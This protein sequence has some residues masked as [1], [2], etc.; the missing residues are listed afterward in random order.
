MGSVDNVALDTLMSITGAT[1]AVITR[2][3]QVPCSGIK[4]LIDL[5]SNRGCSAS[6]LRNFAQTLTPRYIGV[7][8]VEWRTCILQAAGNATGPIK[9]SAE[10]FVLLCVKASTWCTEIVSAD[11]QGRK[12]DRD[13]SVGYLSKIQTAVLKLVTGIFEGLVEKYSPLEPLLFEESLA[14]DVERLI[15]SSFAMVKIVY[16][17]SMKHPSLQSSDNEGM[18]KRCHEL[19]SLTFRLV[20][21]FRR[22]VGGSTSAT[23]GS[24]AFDNQEGC[25]SPERWQLQATSLRIVAS[26]IRSLSELGDLS[27]RGGAISLGLLNVSWKSVVALLQLEEGRDSVASAVDI[28]NIFSSLLHH[29]VQALKAA[30]KSW[31]VSSNSGE[32]DARRLCIPVKFFLQ[33]AEKISSFYPQKAVI[34]SAS[35]ISILSKVYASLLLRYKDVVIQK[36]AMQV[37]AE[38]VIP[39]AIDVLHNLLKAQSVDKELKVKLLHMTTSDTDDLESFHSIAELDGGQEENEV[40][41]ELFNGKT[42]GLGLLKTGRLAIFVSLLQLSSH[43]DIILLRELTLKLH[44]LLDAAPD[45]GVYVVLTQVRLLPIWTADDKITW[46]SQLIFTWLSHS[47]QCFAGVGARDDHVW[48]EFQHFLLENVLHPCAVCRELILDVWCFVIRHC[49]AI[50]AQRHIEVLLSLL[51]DLV[52][53]RVDRPMLRRLAR[54]LCALV[55]E[56]PEILAPRVDADI[57]RRDP[58]SSEITATLA[59]L[60]LEEGYSVTLLN[61]GSRK[62]SFNRLLSCCIAGGKGLVDSL[63][64][65]EINFSKFSAQKH[66]LT[67]LQLLLCESAF[68]GEEIEVQYLQ[69]IALIAQDLLSKTVQEAARLA[70]CR[71]A[72]IVSHALQL[73]PHVQH[74]LDPLYL[75]TL[76][77]KL[78]DCCVVPSRGT[79]SKELKQALPEFLANLSDIVMTEEEENPAMRALWGLFHLVL[80]ETHWALVHMGLA[81]FS[82]YAANTSCQELWRFVPHDAALARKARGDDVTGDVF[83]SA[84]KSFI[85]KE[86]AEN[87][88][89][90]SD[91]EVQLLRSEGALLHKFTDNGVSRRIENVDLD[92]MEIDSVIKDSA[93]VNLTL[94]MICRGTAVLKDILPSWLA[95]KGSGS[96]QWQSIRMRLADLKEDI[97]TLLQ[98]E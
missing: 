55:E 90:P 67:S 95:A 21:T 22:H 96:H 12:S 34:A 81:S 79:T 15:S 92:E 54:V 41:D 60:L 36:T 7:E 26:S 86:G 78:Y 4:L 69:E 2:L 88:L 52:A 1:E 11:L 76:L 56:I 43:Y 66:A 71:N 17:S 24:S 93:E 23:A 63:K 97:G 98:L 8:A 84:L 10:S 80:K 6:N 89:A 75:Q 25:Q 72:E 94:D 91:E 65:E 37:L 83:M 18:R 27:T 58:F 33:M 45:Q 64:Q 46:N 16:L 5:G 49:D 31:L 87:S 42:S 35:I 73:I 51:Q 70:I 9:E 68:R 38:L 62:A 85:E 20:Y 61:Y 44:W 30:V 53:A 47:L 3:L 39:T 48:S 14:S 57:F 74:L 13:L 19:L 40:L 77:P 59:T 32:R 50:S 28:T 82:H 29:S